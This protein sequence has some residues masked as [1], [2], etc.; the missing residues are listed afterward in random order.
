MHKF[1]KAV[2]PVLAV[3]VFFIVGSPCSLWAQNLLGPTTISRVPEI[4]PSS[5]MA[6]MALLAGAMAV[7]RGWRTR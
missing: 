1:G 3:A 6:A 4:D 7:I 5:G 2:I